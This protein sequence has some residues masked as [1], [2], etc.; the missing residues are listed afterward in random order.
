MTIQRKMKNSLSRMC[1]PY[2]ISATE[3][4]FRAKASS[5][6]PNVALRTFIQLPDF[7]ADFNKEGNRANSVKGIAKAMEKP[8]I[9]TVG[10]MTLPCVPTATRRKPMIGPVQE[11]L[12]NDNVNA[13]RKIL[14][15]PVALSDF[16]ST[17]FIHEE[18]S[19]SSKAPR[20]EMP[21]TTNNRKK[22]MLNTA[23]VA[24]AFKA[25]APKASVTTSPRET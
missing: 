13:I 1:H 24:M 22:K 11:K 20:K 14:S 18:G 4:N 23:F 7:G 12:T 15:I 2:A 10:A 16:E 5:M 8:N 19:V 3:R 9:P 17:L 21:K 25:F 6:N